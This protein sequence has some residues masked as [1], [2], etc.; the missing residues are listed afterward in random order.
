MRLGALSVFHIIHIWCYPFVFTVVVVHILHFKRIV[1]VCNLFRNAFLN[2]KKRHKTCF[3]IN[4]QIKYIYSACP[5]NRLG[6]STKEVFNNI[7]VLLKSSFDLPKKILHHPQKNISK[8]RY[9]LYWRTWHFWNIGQWCLKIKAATILPFNKLD[10]LSA[11]LA[12]FVYV[13][14]WRET[15]FCIVKT[16]SYKICTCSKW[17]NT[18]G[19]VE[20]LLTSYLSNSFRMFLFSF[21]TGQTFSNNIRN[22]RRKCAKE[23]FDMILPFLFSFFSKLVKLILNYLKGLEKCSSNLL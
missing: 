7:L 5:S 13:E 17:I 2:V 16:F 14:E 6:I 19:Q 1:M 21:N 20:R 10:L 4:T 11:P 12:F 3:K 22:S 9:Y 18:E 23:N 15:R 8:N